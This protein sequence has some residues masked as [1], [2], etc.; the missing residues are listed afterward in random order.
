MYSNWIQKRKMNIQLACRSVNIFKEIS[1]ED[2]GCSKIF[3]SVALSIQTVKIHCYNYQLLHLER[4]L[5]LF[6]LFSEV[7]ASIF[8]WFLLTVIV[9]SPFILFS[10]SC[11]KCFKIKSNC[12]CSISFFCKKRPLCYFPCYMTGCVIFLKKIGF[13]KEVI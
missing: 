1:C 3:A 12:I 2:N 8:S 9:F 4:Q 7:S 5:Q 6:H 11:S 13:M 10:P